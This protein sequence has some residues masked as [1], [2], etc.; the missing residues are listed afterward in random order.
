MG[1]ERGRGKQI[2]RDG[3]LL[4]SH[5]AL[6]AAYLDFADCQPVCLS[7]YLSV[8]LTHRLTLVPSIC[9]SLSLFGISFFFLC[10]LYWFSSSNLNL[11]L[12]SPSILV[13]NFSKNRHNCRN[14]FTLILKYLGK[15]LFMNIHNYQLSLSVILP[16]GA[17]D[18]YSL[19]KRNC[20]LSLSSSDSFLLCS[21]MIWYQPILP[22]PPFLPHLSLSPSPIT[23]FTLSLV[24]EKQIKINMRRWKV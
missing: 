13:F 16:E 1:A 3:Y 24:C 23:P 2:T 20:S 21:V 9:P 4:K 15:G 10:S 12:R 11:P 14:N 8:S 5:A 17:E 22:P 6:A 19:I 18:I 7:P